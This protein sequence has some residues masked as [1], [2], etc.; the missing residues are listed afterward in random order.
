MNKNNMNNTN[1][2]FA[3]RD[4]HNDAA[5]LIA[6]LT[7]LNKN[8]EAARHYD[9]YKD[10]LEAYKESL[11]KS[12]MMAVGEENYVFVAGDTR[13][14]FDT[15]GIEA[16]LVRLDKLSKKFQVAA[17]AKNRLNEDA[18]NY[19]SALSIILGNAVNELDTLNAL[20]AATAT[21]VNND[22]I[23]ELS[24]EGNRQ[25]MEQEYIRLINE[26]RERVS[27]AEGRVDEFEDISEKVE[28]IYE[29]L[30]IINKRL[31]S[32]EEKAEPPIHI[33][34]KA[35][36]EEKL[37]QNGIIP[38][39]VDE[40]EHYEPKQMEEID[41][42][43]IDVNAGDIMEL[44]NNDITA[45]HTGDIKVGRIGHNINIKIGGNVVINGDDD[46]K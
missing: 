31:T 41:V 20:N 33:P 18:G 7:T 8:I 39:T 45:V 44:D 32:L 24:K 2:G 5:K 40:G 36:D 12:L 37:E 27:I 10:D 4:R 13:Y 14:T 6:L 35:C 46:I 29:E 1:A 16:M 30:A 22:Y 38:N 28:D 23:G 11:T 19:A 17:N 15:N 25:L 21:P 9:E 26:F 43:E 3:K 42:P 34:S